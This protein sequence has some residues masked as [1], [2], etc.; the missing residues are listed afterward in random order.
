MAN[1]NENKKITGKTI[2]IDLGTTFSAISYVEAGKPIII[3]NSEGDRTTPSVVHIKDDDIV[4]GAHA[5]NQSMVDPKSTVRSVKRLMGTKE[6]LEVNGKKYTP[7][8]ISA[9]ILQKLKKDAESYLGTPV[10]NVVI[11]VPAYF[12]DAERQATKDAGEIAGLNVLRIINEPTASALAYG[13]DKKDEHTVLVFDFGG[14]TFDVSILE[15][16]DGVFEVKSTSG[17]NHLGGDD[18]DDLIIDW[19]VDKFK[20]ETGMDLR[21]DANAMQR[22]RDASEK[23]KK[24]LSSKV[25][26][27]INIPYVTLA[28][29]GPKH[30]NYEFTRAEFESLI[31]DILKKLEAPVRKAID[32]SKLKPEEIQKVLLVGGST[33][34]PAVQ[35]LVK[36]ILGKDGD[37][38]INPDEAVALGAALQAAVISGD[39]K[40]I[41]LLDVTPL[42]L[43]IETLGGIFTKMIDRN[44]TIPVKQSKTFSTA[45]NNQTAVSIMV[46]Q[47]ERPMARDNKLLGQ[48]DLVGIPPAPRG[49]PQVEVTFDIDVNGIVSVTAKDKATNKEQSIKITGSTNLSKEDIERMKKEAEQHEKEDK[50]KAEKIETENHA[51]SLVNQTEKMLDEFKD[52][53]DKS[54]KE[55]IEEKIK[56]LKEGIGK[57]DTETLKKKIEDLNKVVSE[58]GA[59]MYQ[60]AQAG[61]QASAGTQNEDGSVN[62][63]FKDKNEKTEE[64]D[65]KE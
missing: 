51:Q 62:T 16:S 32:D 57:D 28:K 36:N 13:L 61:E 8:E 2:G 56:T 29:E 64:K 53:V 43:G 15:I 14:G 52:K 6:T 44:T 54:V 23:A 4:V 3:P 46:Y 10:K 18:I 42:S 5:K 11:T 55:K 50:E 49:V 26:T 60:E 22:V 41:L 47:G 19:V 9:M 40:D 35:E 37:K 58:I 27:A 17:D 59:K 33:R 25:K 7:P 34:I 30:I 63:D 24:E 20:K 38:S 48:F 21:S 31:K 45:E 39:V 12:N 65:K 1:E